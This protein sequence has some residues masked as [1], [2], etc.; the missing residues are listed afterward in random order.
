MKLCVYIGNCPYDG[1]NGFRSRKSTDKNT[2][3]EYNF[4][5]LCRYLKPFMKA[6]D[7]CIASCYKN[8]M[9]YN[10]WENICYLY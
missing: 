10:L 4:R 7:N 8:N 9:L 2:K 1:H 6:E 5:M 3:L